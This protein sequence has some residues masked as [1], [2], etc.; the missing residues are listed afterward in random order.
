MTYVCHD[1]SQAGGLPFLFVCGAGR[2]RYGCEVVGK[3]PDLNG[4][5]SRCEGISHLLSVN[6][7]K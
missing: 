3:V 2:M 6:M 7:R 1:C 5:D 4:Y